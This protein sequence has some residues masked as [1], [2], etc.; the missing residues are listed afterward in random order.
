MSHVSKWTISGSFQQARRNSECNLEWRRVERKWSG[1]GAAF[2][3]KDYRI[4]AIAPR[5]A[6][7]SGQEEEHE[8]PGIPAVLAVNY[9][10]GRNATNSPFAQLLSVN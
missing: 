10:A 4:S 5:S 3:D 7:R 9:A 8:S 6:K 2:P 1:N